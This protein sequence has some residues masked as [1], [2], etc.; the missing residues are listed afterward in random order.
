MSE[1]VEE[2]HI[3]ARLRRSDVPG[4]IGLPA[5]DATRA[6]TTPITTLRSSTV[7]VAKRAPR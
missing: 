6:V 7:P 5:I 2:R 1:F 3:P 4:M